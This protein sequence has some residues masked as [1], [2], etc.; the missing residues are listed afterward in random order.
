[1]TS[2]SPPASGPRHVAIIMDGNGRW[3]Q[4]R[5]RPRLFGHHAGA[6]RVREIVEACPSNGVKYLTIFAFSTENWK[7]TQ[8]EVAGLMSLFRRYILKEMQDFVKRNVRV[9]FIGDRVR[10]DEKLRGLM[11]EAEELTA[12]C[13]GTNLTIALNYGGRDEVA[14]ATHRLAQDVAAGKLD[15]NKVDEETLPKYLD[16]HVLPDP[17]LV[18]RT[19]GE[20]RISN[21]LLWQSAYAEYE[22]IDTLWPDFSAEEFHTLV[23]GYGGRDRR[24]GAVTA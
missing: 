12:H 4:A 14:R 21:F 19:S 24:F 9:R 17:D 11:D 10:L 16:T 3:A 8:I 5:G 1:M 7:R 23:S 2:D 6:R 22:F 20:A 15:P 13:T 18:I